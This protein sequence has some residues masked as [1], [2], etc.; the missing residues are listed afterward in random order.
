MRQVLQQ[1]FHVPAVWVEEGSRNTFENAL[2]SGALLK[3]AGIQRIY[4]VTH[5][6]HMRRARI[7][8]EHAG[9]TVIAAPT[10]FATRYK[11]TVLDFL[12][13]ARA[14][15][16]SGVFFREG[17]GIVWYTLRSLVGRWTRSQ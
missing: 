3:P 4:L 1:D 2:Q 12:P 5:A 9:F 13:D 16:D 15:H 10:G 6:W 14:L 7:A 17:A 8:F 11:L